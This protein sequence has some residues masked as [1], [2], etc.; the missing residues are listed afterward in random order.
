MP[1]KDLDDPGTGGGGGDVTSCFGR[2]GAVIGQAGD[3]NADQINNGS[4]NRFNESLQV[5]NQSGAT[6]VKGTPVYVVGTHASGKAIVQQASND[7]PAKMPCVG[8]VSDDIADGNEGLVLIRGI[9][10]QIDTS[11]LSVGKVLYVG[12][13]SG[14]AYSQTKPAGNALIQN[15]G[16]VVRSHASNGSFEVQGSGRTNDL[17][18]LANGYMWVGDG[19]GVPTQVIA[20]SNGGFT[21]YEANDGN[22]PFTI[23]T[24]DAVVEVHNALGDI[25][26]ILPTIDGASIGKEI[27]M[28]IEHNPANN[29][30]TVKAPSTSDTINEIAADGAEVAKAEYSSNAPNFLRVTAQ[31]LAANSAYIDQATSVYNALRYVVNFEAK[32][33]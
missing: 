13:N 2:T 8:V 32:R 26:L 29:K 19:S 27:K 31:S 33:F 18:N 7:D 20:P 25:E 22:T 17:P 24:W 14:S 1:Y 10:T 5:L 9:L 11:S 4:I 3:Y 16:Y 21:K 15:M 30:V 12:T 23:P 28:W 6:L